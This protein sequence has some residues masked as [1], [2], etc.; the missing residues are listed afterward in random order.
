[1]SV[2]KQVFYI[3]GTSIFLAFYGKIKKGSVVPVIST[4][5]GLNNPRIAY[6]VKFCKP[7][8]QPVVDYFIFQMENGFEIGAQCC[9]YVKGE[10]VVDICGYY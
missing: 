5:F 7:E 3:L 4:L 2:K 6:S 1:M 10:K 8:Y 9:A